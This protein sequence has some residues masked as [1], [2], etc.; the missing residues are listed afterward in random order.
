MDRD[1]YCMGLAGKIGKQAREATFIFYDIDCVYGT[2]HS[3]LDLYVK[4]KSNLEF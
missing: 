1:L 3:Y 4:M 2:V